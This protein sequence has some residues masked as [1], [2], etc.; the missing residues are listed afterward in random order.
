MYIQLA[1]CV[2]ENLPKILNSVYAFVLVVNVFIHNKC[3]IVC[4]FIHSMK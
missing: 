4:T 1:L 3:K 2:D